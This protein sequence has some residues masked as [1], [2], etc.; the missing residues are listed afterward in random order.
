MSST[1]LRPS[2]SAPV[3]FSPQCAW[4]LSA[5]R[6]LWQY[7]RG[8]FLAFVSGSLG[9][10]LA[11]WLLLTQVSDWLLTPRPAIPPDVR[12]IM[13]SE[14]HLERALAM[15]PIDRSGPRWSVNLRVQ[16]LRVSPTF[17][18][19]AIADTLEMALG[20]PLQPEFAPD[21][22]LSEPPPVIGRFERRIRIPAD[23]PTII[24]Q[25]PE[26]LAEADPELTW[27]TAD[28][29]EESVGVAIEEQAAVD[30]PDVNTQEPAPNEPPQ[31]QFAILPEGLL[32]GFAESWPVSSEASPVS[33]GE[34]LPARPR[35]VEDLPRIETAEAA[36]RVVAN[37]VPMSEPERI[38]IPAVAENPAPSTACEL[39]LSLQ[40]YSSGEA[41]AGSLHRLVLIARNHGPV[42]LRGV[43]LLTQLPQAV[44]HERGGDLELALEPLAPGESREIPLW[45]RPRT[46]ELVVLRTRG[47]GS[48][49]RVETA[50]VLQVKPRITAAAATGLGTSPPPAR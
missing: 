37:P 27:E 29:Q 24:E 40:W 32:P 38:T 45:I 35:L 25:P 31:P 21:P 41:T 5:G 28:E 12:R 10:L 15:P 30:P 23:A 8:F 26:S 47:L 18:S 17:K 48:C 34:W 16:E 11:F 33:L 42:P 1:I 39:P 44:W 3:E 20:P 22:R 7:N 49:G 36:T 2:E 9:M 13:N 50:G 19:P 46:D 14:S 6:W 43:V 4:L